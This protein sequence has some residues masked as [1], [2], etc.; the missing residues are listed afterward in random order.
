M[1][2]VVIALGVFLVEMLVWWLTPDGSSLVEWVRYRQEDPIARWGSNMGRRLSRTDSNGWFARF[3]YT[4]L[5]VLHAWNNMTFRDC[6]EILFLRPCEIVNM[7]WLVYIVTAQTFGSYKNC[8]CQAS[9]WGSHGVST[10]LLMTCAFTDKICFQG[11][12]DFAT[13]ETY[14][15]HGV[16]YYWGTGTALT[17]SVLTVSLFFIVVEYCTQSHLSTEEYENA[18]QGLWAVRKY[19][20]YTYYFRRV[21]DY[22]IDVVK[23]VF[24]QLLGNRVRSG[25]R[26][27]V[28]TSKVHRHHPPPPRLVIGS[29]AAGSGDDDAEDIPLTAPSNTERRDSRSS[30]GGSTY[31]DNASLQPPPLA[32]ANLSFG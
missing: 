2:F 16:Y 24:H 12:I 21:P 9:T 18:S 23:R 7:G 29:A 27:L 32:R 1:I 19:K 20:K 5:A 14:R 4:A 8:D 31:S 22:F 15:E 6:M 25:R 28:W 26:S 11:Y 3:K 10:E 30:I 13:S 17:C